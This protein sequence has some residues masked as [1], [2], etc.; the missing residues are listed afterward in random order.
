MKTLLLM[1]HAKSSKDDP[2]I[3]DI[4]RPLNKRGKDDAPE[5][6]KRLRK[7]NYLP[8]LMISSP[9]KRAIATAR[10]VA[11]ELGYKE[12][13][14]ELE[15]A[16]YEASVRDLLEVI[17]S[18]PDAANQVMLFGHNPGFNDLIGYISGDYIDNLPTSGIAAFTFNFDSW[19][20]VSKENG[21]MIML[22]FPKKGK[23]E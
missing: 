2:T 13:E 19:Q 18:L 9:A 17:R 23:D 12:D 4:E 10:L 5:M 15:T 22:D 6:G 8:D 3:A 14:I 11:E 16:I 1:R 21:K 20:H 7:K